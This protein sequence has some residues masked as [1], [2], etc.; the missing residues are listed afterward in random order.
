MSVAAQTFYP[1]IISSVLY[2]FIFGLAIG[3]FVKNID[4]FNYLTFLIPGLI[5]MNII[6]SAYA[7]TSSSLFIA[8]FLKSIE[9]MLVSP[10]SYM[11]MVLAYVL[12]GIV[13]GL[14]VGGV[15]LIIS[16]FF[17]K[18]PFVN[19]PLML[20]FAIFTSIIFSCIGILI[21]LVSEKFDHLSILTTFIINPLTYLGGVF[22][23]TKM[24]PPMLAKVTYF[25]PMFY[26]I[27]GLRYSMLGIQEGNIWFA[28][29]LVFFMGVGLFLL[30]VYLF[31]IG[32]KIRQ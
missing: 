19:I 1:P 2:M 15:I 24:L 11:E 23:S 26:M 14:L 32:Y 12:G 5:M 10:L 22:Y 25:N 27:S 20:F 31:K 17:V 6:N 8:R 29:G 13:R 30:C 3:S 28:T 21:A 4:G 16:F 18:I 9:D 7:N